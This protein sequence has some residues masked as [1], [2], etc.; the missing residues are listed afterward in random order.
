MKF[1][2]D[3][4]E[5]SVNDIKVNRSNV[6]IAH[7]GDEDHGIIEND[8]ASRFPCQ[9]LVVEDNIVNQQILLLMLERLGY[10]ADRASNGL[11]AV[12]LL[13]KQNYDLIFM[14]IQMPIMDGLNACQQ[15]RGLR[16]RNPW[17]V[18]LSAHAFRESREQALNKGMNDYITKP[19]QIEQ[20][21][22]TLHNL[23]QGQANLH[24]SNN[25]EDHGKGMQVGSDWQDANAQNNLSYTDLHLKPIAD[26][27]F[28]HD[29]NDEFRDITPYSVH[30]ELDFA[31]NDLDVIDLKSILHLEEYLGKVAMVEVIESYLVESDKMILKM[32]QALNNMDFEQI[33]AENHALKGGCATI[34]ALRLSAIC[35]EISRINK[36]K[37]H[38]N[39]YQIL[40][41]LLQKLDVEFSR[42]S[43]FLRDYMVG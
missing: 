15:I 12:N 19:L 21:T 31:V 13:K 33:S 37:L 38:A 24:P 9:I 43:K 26:A 27:L 5:R 7:L 41:A 20:L 34:G 25:H 28:A 18:G 8:F 40:D 3:S 30:F 17:I 14:D 1:S 11:E 2:S 35:K 42:A 16:D 4:F 36:Y 22:Q 39:K 32:R 10:A 29:Q 23:S 6:A